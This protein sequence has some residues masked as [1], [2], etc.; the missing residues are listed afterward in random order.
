MW[1]R[2]RKTRRARA[3][4]GIGA[5]RA[6][7]LLRA[8]EAERSSSGSGGDAVPFVLAFAGGGGGILEDVTASGGGGGLTVV[9][10]VQL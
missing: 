3:S 10:D 1:K 8:G 2:I 7:V 9:I 6:Q 5:V 4:T